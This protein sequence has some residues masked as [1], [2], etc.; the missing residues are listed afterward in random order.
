MTLYF[1][2]QYVSKYIACLPCFP[3]RVTVLT[4]DVT[5]SPP[6]GCLLCSSRSGFSLTTLPDHHLLNM[7]NPPQATE[8]EVQLL[9]SLRGSLEVLQSKVADAEHQWLEASY[10]LK[11]A[12]I[13][14]D[15]ASTMFCSQLRTMISDAQ[16]ERCVDE[17]E[18]GE[19]QDRKTRHKMARHLD[20]EWENILEA[21]HVRLDEA[22]E[23]AGKLGTSQ[24]ER[25][26]QDR[27]RRDRDAHEIQSLKVE[28]T[29]ALEKANVEFEIRLGEEKKRVMEEELRAKVEQSYADLMQRHQDLEQRY[30]D[31]RG[32]ADR[33]TAELNARSAGSA[34]RAQEPSPG[35]SGASPPNNFPQQTPTPPYAGMPSGSAPRT[36]EPPLGQSS[37]FVFTPPPGAPQWQARTPQSP[38]VFSSPRQRPRERQN[39]SPNLPRPPAQEQSRCKLGPNC[40]HCAEER[41]WREEAKARQAEE[42]ARQQADDERAKIEAR[43]R[44][45]SEAERLRA[46]AEAER[47]SR[48]EE[49]VREE[50]EKT[51]QER[52]KTNRLSFELQ[53]M[54]QAQ[55]DELRLR[56]EYA[57]WNTY[58]GAWSVLGG[59]LSFSA[60]PWPMIDAPRS[61]GDISLSSIRA[62][63]F[64][65][66]HPGEQP[67]KDR[68][69]KALLR[70]HPD[71][72]CNK[73]HRVAD[74]DK[75]AVYEAVKLVAGYLNV[76]L[77][78]CSQR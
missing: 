20:K 77:H 65:R 7:S 38:F 21:L 18:T 48:A 75:N 57:S 66:S 26:E 51:R 55:A 70:W 30:R 25:E 6:R 50:Q 11:D 40:S 35:P 44:E 64:S 41:R 19:R 68:V 63:L 62:F 22:R 56:K 12:R 39:P 67:N 45:L 16:I 74:N 47:A 8:S 58:E 52:E 15:R 1:F 61:P 4:C 60:V 27:R 29:R 9:S 53:Q 10:E 76:L 73:M 32:E 34:P 71:K 2:N 3:R 42:R 14:R 37:P 69:K 33:A 17:Y 54:K 31:A 59:A 49:S 43:A 78:E 28:R 5:D 46:D 72:F 13:R 23:T 24:H 36:Q